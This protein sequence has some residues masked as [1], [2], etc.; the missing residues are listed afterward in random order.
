MCACSRPESRD[1][2]AAVPEFFGDS[3]RWHDAAYVASETVGLLMQLP[4]Y[5]EAG[6]R[7]QIGA[8]LA[9]ASADAQLLVMVQDVVDRCFDDPNSP[10]RNE[11]L[12]IVYLEELLRLPVLTEGERL[13]PEHRLAMARRNRPGTAATDFAYVCRDG[14]RRTLHATAPGKRLLLVFYDPECAHCTEILNMVHNSA[15][16]AGA[17]RG[18]MLEVLAVYTEGNRRVWEDTA[19]SMPREWT[20]ACDIDSIV[21]RELYDIPAMPVMYLLDAD[22][23]V[24]LKDAPLPTLESLLLAR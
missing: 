19:D 5:D 9:V 8:L 12:Y 22:K 6:R 14:R 3:L 4:Q 11:E 16:V 23:T 13:R 21:D 15:A 18:G 24:L 1:T 7:R 20:V 2:T 10:M 17:V